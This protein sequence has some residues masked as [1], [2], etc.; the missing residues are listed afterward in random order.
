MSL[1][2]LEMYQNYFAFGFLLNIAVMIGFGMY[3]TSNISENQAVY[4]VSKY[5]TKVNLSR[6]A[7]LLI[8]PFLGFLYV[9][10]ELVA[11]QFLYLNRGQTV[12]NY[13]EDRIKR[14][15]KER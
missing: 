15:S 7:V 10:K 9:F 12:F 3:K 1:D 4:L 5:E 11:L 2:F 13:I 6:M 8:V 14:N